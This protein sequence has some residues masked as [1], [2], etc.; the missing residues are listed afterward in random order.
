MFHASQNDDYFKVIL[1]RVK[2][3]YLT[4]CEQILDL[5][6]AR[7]PVSKSLNDLGCNVGQFYKALLRRQL[8][9]AY[10]GYDIEALYL[11]TAASL[12]PS[13]DFRSIDLTAEKPERADISVSSATIELIA[14]PYPALEHLLAT[15][16]ETA[17]IRTFL[18]ETHLVDAYQKEGAERPYMI[19]QFSFSEVEE[20]C[21]RHGFSIEVIHD[22]YTG[23]EPKDLGQN[24]I[25]SAYVVMARKR[26]Q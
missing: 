18:G 4:W 26:T 22:R 5:I 14:D 9:L 17:F 7:C 1:D 25:R 6:E 12:F 10:R 16:A 21:D 13:A 15:T 23:S 2:N 24:V 19:H 20:I 8:A 3:Q 11:K